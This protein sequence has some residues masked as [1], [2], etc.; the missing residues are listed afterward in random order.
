MF[1]IDIGPFLIAAGI[2]SAVLVFLIIPAAI[3]SSEMQAEEE[4]EHWDC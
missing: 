4:I 1:G 3:I 2:S